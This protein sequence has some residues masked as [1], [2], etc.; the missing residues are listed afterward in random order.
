MLSSETIFALATP[1][2]RSGVAIIRVS[3]PCACKSVERLISKPLPKSGRVLRTVSNS[4]GEMIDE[5][6]ILTFEQGASFTGEE[7]VEIQCHGSPAVIGEILTAIDETG[8]SKPAE[9]G[10]FTR[11][12]L[13]NGLLDLSQVEGLADLLEA[14]TKQQLKQAVRVFRGGLSEAVLKWR[15]NLTKAAAL[16]EATIDFADEE[17]P[18]DVSPEVID[19]L[20]SVLEDLREQISSSRMTERL[21]DGF[22]VAIIGPPNIGKST[23]INR[24]AGREAAITSDIAGTTRDV[25]EVHADIDG[26]PVTFVDTAGLRDTEETVEALGVELARKRAAQADFR[27]FLRDEAEPDPGLF[28]SGDLVYFGHGDKANVKSPSISGLTGKNV[29]ELI[30]AISTKLA[31]HVSEDSLLTRQRH[32]AAVLKAISHL[33]SS[34]SFLESGT[35]ESEIIAE[36]IRSASRSLQIM[37]GEIGVEDILGDIFSSFCIGK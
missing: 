19:L 15:K 7:V 27:V 22:E 13:E 31:S 35:T 36:E 12:A 1:K 5:C 21:R 26:L 25:I 24:L 23:L 9:A 2:G 29:E 20:L 28:Q 33:E 3:G 18:T 30:S 14:D 10:E 16:L 11:R 6:L 37:V 32:K 4:A 34:V 17:V 8:L